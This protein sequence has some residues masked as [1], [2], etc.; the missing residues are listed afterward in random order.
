MG[1]FERARA[2]VLLNVAVPTPTH[3]AGFWRRI[4]D[5]ADWRSA[6]YGVLL[7]PVGVVTGTV[8]LAGWVTTGAALTYLMYGTGFRRQ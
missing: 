4:L 8:T 6:L 1:H 5:G 3:P 2:R 7:L